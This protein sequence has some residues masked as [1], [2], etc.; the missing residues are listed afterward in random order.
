MDNKNEVRTMTGT[1][2]WFAVVKTSGMIQGDDGVNYFVHRSYIKQSFSQAER[3]RV[4]FL[5]EGWRVRFE[6]GQDE[7]KGIPA[8]HNV[9]LEGSVGGVQL[10]A[11]QPAVQLTPEELGHVR[12]DSA[13][14]LV[15]TLGKGTQQRAVA[16][17]ITTNRFKAYSVGERHLRVFNLRLP[18]GDE[19]GW[20]MLLGTDKTARKDPPRPTS[21]ERGCYVYENVA[22]GSYVVRLVPQKRDDGAKPTKATL[23]LHVVG[24]RIQDKPEVAHVTNPEEK[25]GKQDHWVI[26]E[27]VTETTINLLE[28]YEEDLKLRSDIM[29]VDLLAQVTADPKLSFINDRHNFA[30][31]MARAMN[32]LGTAGKEWEKETAA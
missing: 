31:A 15:L 20:F 11:D 4:Q 1:V 28:N 2:L 26:L 16:A 27:K 14:R 21:D 18:V 8:A 3:C 17:H 10:R 13:G 25:R 6:I 32:I 19:A 12:V 22:M 29:A 24:R 23:T 30:K 7:E 9:Q 5:L